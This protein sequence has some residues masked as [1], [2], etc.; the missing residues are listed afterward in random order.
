M[1]RKRKLVLYLSAVVICTA[2]I[3]LS[4]KKLSDDRYRAQ[5]PDLPDMQDLSKPLQEQ[6][7]IAGKKAYRNPT[8]FNLGMLGMV[9]HSSAYYDKA[10]RCYRL[11]VQKNKNKPV[12]S[13]YLGYL[14]LELNNSKESIENFSRV[15]KKNPGNYL[16]WYY[17]G[18]AYQNLG[19]VD[20]AEK[21]FNKISAL[22]DQD[23]DVNNTIRINHF[24]LRTFAGFDLA[25]IYLNTN[26]LDM[27]EKTLKEVIQ[28]QL[29]F[30]PAYRLLGNVYSMKGEEALSNHFITRSKDLAD[31]TPPLVDHLTD[32][33]ILISR[34]EQYLLKQ[35]DIAIQSNNLQ[36]ALKLCDKAMLYTPENKFLISKTIGVY[37]NLGLGK[38]ALT[39][40]DRHISDFSDDYSELMRLANLLNEK[41]FPAQSMMYFSMAKKLKPQN[42]YLPQWLAKT[43]FF[44]EAVAL[45]NEQLETDP[46]NADFL[47]NEILIYLN[48]GEIEKAKLYL[49]RLK[50]VSPSNPDVK[51]FTGVLAEKEGNIK[52]AISAYEEVF[53]GDPKNLP[54]IKGLG[55]FYISENKWD[56]AINL[57]RQALDSNP[58]EPYLL[59]EFAKLMLF[60]PDS[61]LRNINSGREYAERAYINFKSNFNIRL[62]AAKNLTTAYAALGDKNQAVFYMKITL[63]LAKEG[64]LT[65]DYLFYFEN[66]KKQ[67]NLP[68]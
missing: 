41:G 32:S 62:S 3:L 7:S 24:P 26:R 54:I 27:A 56:K 40:M 16:A 23:S 14:N 49:I 48:T 34:S 25:R 50:G 64:N 55:N 12:W 65:Q 35:I 63:N 17:T 51:K 18:E 66:L 20:V 8:A 31:F 19:M 67:Y 68:D 22:K 29:K 11:A 43:G 53:K 46:G 39:L 45:M 44:K 58:N 61:N 28:D 30:G 10:T 47:S 60:C 38:Q 9:Y 36:W 6:I 59:D 15:I 1:N 4:L 57:Y 42:P 21:Y 37:L 33:L 5:I 13:Y 2:I 52:K